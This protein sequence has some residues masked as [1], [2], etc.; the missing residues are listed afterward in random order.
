M[1]RAMRWLFDN[2]DGAVD[3]IAK[4]LKLKAEYARRGY[5]SIRTKGCGTPI[6]ASTLPA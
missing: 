1:I 2:R 5:A 3:F 4:E 6:Y